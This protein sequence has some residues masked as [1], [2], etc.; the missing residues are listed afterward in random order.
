MVELGRGLKTYFVLSS[1]ALGWIIYYEYKKQSD[2]Y[3]LMITLQTKPIDVLALCNFG[4]VLTDIL[5]LVFLKIFFGELRTV[6]VS[7]LYDQF[8]KNLINII[9]IFYF[10]HLELTDK[11][12][13]IFIIYPMLMFLLHKLAHKRLEFL[14][15]TRNRDYVG[16]AKLGVLLVILLCIDLFSLKILYPSVSRFNREVK[17]VDILCIYTFAEIS[18]MTTYLTIGFIRYFVNL[19][20]IV[21]L[22]EFENKDT[23]FKV[24][25][26]LISILCFGIDTFTIYMITNSSRSVPYFFIG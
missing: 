13:L 22:Y 6:E 5:V 21:I 1:I 25:L 17:N 9:I 18:K 12:S 24:I 10:L 15:S 19:I 14:A 8:I 23:F 16:Y 4:L 3:N 2:F 20:E 11:M 7:Y 26:L